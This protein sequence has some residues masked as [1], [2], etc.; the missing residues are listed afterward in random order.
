ML[1]PLTTSWIAYRGAVLAAIA[2][3]E[4]IDTAFDLHRFD[5]IAALRLPLPADDIEE[6]KAYTALC[7]YWRQ[8]ITTPTHYRH[9]SGAPS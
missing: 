5:L 9:D 4:S 8:G 2:Y 6:R 1:I 7:D 3:G